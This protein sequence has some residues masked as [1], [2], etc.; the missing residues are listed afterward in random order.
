MALMSDARVVSDNFMEE[1][2]KAIRT[3][4]F[5]DLLQQIGTK[6]GG[7]GIG[8]NQSV[9]TCLE[10]YFDDGLVVNTYFNVQLRFKFNNFFCFAKMGKS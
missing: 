2:Q 6:G 4:I 9:L 8:L 5:W 7:G 1:W 3:R 10:T